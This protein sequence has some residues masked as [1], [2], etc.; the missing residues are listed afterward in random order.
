VCGFNRVDVS[1]N[2]FLNLLLTLVDLGRRVFLSRL[3]RTLN[4][5]PSMATV[6]A[7]IGSSIALE[8]L[9]RTI[10]RVRAMV[11]PDLARNERLPHQKIVFSTAWANVEPYDAFHSMRIEMAS[12]RVNP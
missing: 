10:E 9:P 4:L 1:L 5:L 7:D 11:P 8:G 6:S 3:F 2:A 12:V